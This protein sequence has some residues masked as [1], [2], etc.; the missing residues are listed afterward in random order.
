MTHV[1]KSHMCYQVGQPG[2]P[3]VLIVHTLKDRAMLEGRA[4][5]L[6]DWYVFTFL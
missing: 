6:L 3:P 4:V 5:L 1:I 2:A